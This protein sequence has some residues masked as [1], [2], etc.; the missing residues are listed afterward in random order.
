MVVLGEVLSQ[1]ILNLKTL[2][3]SVMLHLVLFP[4]KLAV[5]EPIIP[6]ASYLDDKNN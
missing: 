6:V 2:K 1:L 5:F 3:F 4:L